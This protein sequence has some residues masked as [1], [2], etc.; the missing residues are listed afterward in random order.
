MSRPTLLAVAGWLV[1]AT[2]AT[3]TGLAAVRV[4][5]D[6]ITGTAAAT[7]SER[8]VEERLASARP[9]VTVSPHASAGQG[10]GTVL[11]SAAGTIVATCE[12][13]LVTLLSWAPEQGYSVVEADP[14][15]DDEAEVEFARGSERVEVKVVC[16]AGKPAISREKDD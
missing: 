12:N 2:V 15:P 5:G 4:I 6:G 9:G 1:A 3:L 14:G 13:G 8:E 16:T 7:L 10:G 11:T